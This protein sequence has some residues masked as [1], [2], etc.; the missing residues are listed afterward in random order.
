MT[1]W[2][3]DPVDI[4]VPPDELQLILATINSH[5]ELTEDVMAT[6]LRI[7]GNL[8][9]PNTER[10]LLMAMQNHTGP[11]IVVLRV[12]DFEKPQGV[13]TLTPVLPEH[14]DD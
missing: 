1:D 9:P 2:R 13:I 10:W 11:D 4:E 5:P 3:H 6:L 8:I 12:N 14:D 7:L